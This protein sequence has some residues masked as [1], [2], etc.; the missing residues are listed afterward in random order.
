[1]A[2]KNHARLISGTDERAIYGARP[3]NASGAPSSEFNLE[4]SR[5]GE[6]VSAREAEVTLLPSFCA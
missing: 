4:I 6:T 5:E 1:V 2:Y 3:P